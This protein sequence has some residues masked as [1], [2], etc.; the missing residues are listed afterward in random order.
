MGDTTFSTLLVAFVMNT[1]II[2]GAPLLVAT[3]VGLIVSIFQAVTQIQD[4]TLSQTV[5]IFAIGF[6]FLTFGGA[7]IGPLVA[8]SADL[9]DTFATIGR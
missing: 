9:F 1:A 5:K 6:V 4:Q 3:V 2:A 8:I 7:L